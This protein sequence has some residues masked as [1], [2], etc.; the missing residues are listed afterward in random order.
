MFGAINVI[1]QK[2]ITYRV[3]DDD[4]RFWCH[5]T[6]LY[7]N[8]LYILYIYIHIYNDIIYK[9]SRTHI[10]S[11]I[12]HVVFSGH[13]TNIKVKKKSGNFVF[14]SPSLMKLPYTEN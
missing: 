11:C 4:D 12:S 7:R 13:N 5:M 14:F 2:N 3:D 8:T 9:M 10:R 1:K 6:I